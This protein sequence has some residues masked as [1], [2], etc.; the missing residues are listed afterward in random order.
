MDRPQELIEYRSLVIEKNKLDAKIK[1]L[2]P[3]VGELLEESGGYDDLYLQKVE[4]AVWHEDVIFDWMQEN[5]P[6]LVSE[7]AKMTVDIEKF[8]ELAKRGLL[9]FEDL[10]QSC[11]TIKTEWHVKTTPKK[12]EEVNE[13]SSDSR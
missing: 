10:P 9:A 11:M 6:A 4:K 12:K 5:H 3:V 1:K 13:D 8:G 2:R 7:V